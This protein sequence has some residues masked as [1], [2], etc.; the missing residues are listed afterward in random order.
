MKRFLLLSRVVLLIWI[1][2]P[3][4]QAQYEEDA[5]LRYSTPGLGVG[6]R[7]LG[8]GTAYTGV[9][10]DF[11]AVYWNPAGL[12]QMRLNEVSLGLS[13]L[14]FGNTST[15]L[16]NQQSF[17][18]SSTSFN[19]FG[20][21]YPIPTARGS[22]VIAIGY[23]RQADYTTGLSFR[24]YNPQ[25]S[26]VQAWA[27]NGQSLTPDPTIA[28]DL[29]LAYA[30]T[31]TGKFVSPINGRLTQIGMVLES[32]GQNNITVS[33]AVE[34]AKNFYVGASLNFITGSHSYVSKYS[35]NDLSNKYNSSTLA[36]YN[37]GQSTSVFDLNYLTFDET[38]EHDISGFSAKLGILYKFASGTRLGLAVKTP[39]WITV[40]Q[41]YSPLATST[42]DNGDQFTFPSGDYVP[43]KTDYDITTPFIFSAGISH[44]FG[45]L[46]LAGDVEYT[47]WTQIEFSNA[48]ARLLGYNTDI[49]TLFRPTANLRGGAEYEFSNAGVRL[50]GGFVYLPSPFNGDPSSFA[51]KYITGGLGFIVEDAFAIDIGYAHGFWKTYQINLDGVSRTDEDIS[52]SNLI[53]TVTYRF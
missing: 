22:M 6:A 53:G 20:L 26:I 8:M 12:G 11:S 25:S 2:M 5:A 38:M 41:T 28:E 35:E 31:I 36:T 13:N 32:G 10:N 50:R 30:D 44:P 48:D 15:L 39:S 43:Q 19:S 21:V 27:P 23:D 51:Q 17:T 18:N 42:F 3:T 47:D 49:K 4:A 37:N 7:A 33:G 16:S 14:S 40:N 34:A 46:L 45:D 52:T 1:V 9:A 29:L 24:A